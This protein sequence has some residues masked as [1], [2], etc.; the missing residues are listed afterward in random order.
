MSLPK[1]T[2]SAEV[3]QTSTG[4][5]GPDQIEH[6]LDVIFAMF[7]P[8]ATGLG[9][10]N[11]KDNTV[12]DAKLGNRT[13]DQA[14]ATAYANTGTPTQLLSW[15]VKAI[16]AMKGT[17]TNWYDAGAATIETLWG[18]FNASSGHNH[19]GTTNNGA[20]V[21]HLMLSNGGTNTHAQIDTAIGVT[22]PGLVTTHAGLTV[23]GT[24]GSTS[25]AWGS[26]LV[27][28]DAAG[29][30]KVVDPLLDDDV[31]TYKTAKDQA[32]IAKGEAIAAITVDISAAFDDIVSVLQG[33]LPPG[34]SDFLY[35][36]DDE[37]IVGSVGIVCI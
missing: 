13:V 32:A 36:E 12:T 22:L 25:A 35:T 1:R 26:R 30:T 33:T 4:T 5:R 17:V 10:D 24:H 28:R 15:I 27:H 29:R 2:F 20:Q 31:A 34:A 14:I 16:L 37:W 23:E 21:S 11:I 9:T 19:D 7:D 3:G 18:K 6:D 8:S